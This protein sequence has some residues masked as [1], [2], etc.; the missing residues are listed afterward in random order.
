M[1]KI[2]EF[3][4][5]KGMTYQ[6]AKDYLVKMGKWDGVKGYDGY[7]V[8]EYACWLKEENADG[9]KGNAQRTSKT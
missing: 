5:I 4:Q 9:N 7:S 3:E 8:V 2:S 1:G 6:E